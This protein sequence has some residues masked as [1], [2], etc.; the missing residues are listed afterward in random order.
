MQDAL[1]LQQSA[2]P[3]GFSL[4]CRTTDFVQAQGREGVR[5]NEATSKKK[6]KPTTAI[7]RDLSLEETGSV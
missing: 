1:Q 6:A 2:V 5:M 3:L 4:N 7:I